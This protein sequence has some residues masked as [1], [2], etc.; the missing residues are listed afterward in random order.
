MRSIKALLVSIVL[1]SFG[2]ATRADDLPDAKIEL[3]AAID[4]LKAGHMNSGKMDWPAVRAKALAMLGDAT[5]PE[6]AY[7]AIRYVIDQLGEKHTAL[8]TADETKALMTGTQV[9]KAQSPDWQMPEGHLL[10]GEIGLLSLKAIMGAPANQLAYANAARAAL[11]SFADG[12][13]C[14]YIIDLRSNE[15]GN[16]D[17]MINGVEALLGKPPYGFWQPAGGTSDLAWMLKRGAFQ[18]EAV[19]ADE[20][21]QSKASVAV[22]IDRRTSSSGEMTALAFKGR[23]NTRMFGENSAGFL[24]TNYP[25]A[26]PDGARLII[27]SGWATDRLRRTYRDVIAPDEVTPRGQGTL[28][29]AI[30]WL[31]NQPCP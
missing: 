25:A 24:T 21:V 29:A 1:L 17:P 22:L 18:H 19:P 2:Q 15:G 12:K 16:M 28:D 8:R 3:N 7:P 30:V 23:P 10:E 20:P 27:S 26:L 14:R 6:E 4:L 31:K 11:Q 9:G 13:V 5:K